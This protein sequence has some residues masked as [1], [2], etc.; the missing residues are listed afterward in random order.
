[1]MPCQFIPDEYSTNKWKQVF[2]NP[3]A[4]HYSLVR[5]ATSVVMNL[6]LMITIQRSQV[7]VIIISLEYVP[8]MS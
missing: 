5:A 6:P 2:D 8:L 4:E 7:C 3:D 1:M